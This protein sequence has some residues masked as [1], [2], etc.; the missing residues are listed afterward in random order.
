MSAR[1]RPEKY[2][3]FEISVEQKLSFLEMPEQ[4]Q[5]IPFILKDGVRPRLIAER[6]AK[7]DA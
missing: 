3:F 5:V 2:A 6:R 7:I 1:M 4:G